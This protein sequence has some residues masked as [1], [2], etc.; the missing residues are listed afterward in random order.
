MLH[1]NAELC[2]GLGGVRLVFGFCGLDAFFIA[3][4]QPL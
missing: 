1:N 4:L 3:E 2:A